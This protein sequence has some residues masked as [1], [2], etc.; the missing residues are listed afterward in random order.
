M[1]NYLKLEKIGTGSGGCTVSKMKD[2]TNG[3]VNIINNI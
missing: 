2:L 3:N 1:E